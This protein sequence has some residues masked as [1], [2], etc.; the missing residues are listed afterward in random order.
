MIAV[1]AVVGLGV[2]LT[3]VGLEDADKLASVLGLFVALAGLGV[4]VYGVIAD[5]KSS[6]DEHDDQDTSTPG[7]SSITVD[8]DNNGIVSDGE[9]AS[10]TQMNATASE[11]GRVYQAG[12]D[13]TIN[14]R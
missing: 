14:E 12:R 7:E 4:A 8:G 1:T 3:R 11:Q 9:G 13:Q 5:R 6:S 10:N 2:Y